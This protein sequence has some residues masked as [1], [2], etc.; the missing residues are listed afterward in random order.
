MKSTFTATFI[1]FTLI[2]LS[3]C[4]Q[5][6]K[7]EKTDQKDSLSLTSTPDDSLLNLIQKQTFTYFW[8]GAEPN[9][10]LA[11]ERIHIDGVY[12]LNDQNVI[13]IGGSGFGLMGMLVAMERQFITKEQGYERLTKAL[14][15]LE[16]IERFH[17]AWAHW[18]DGTTGEAKPFSKND[19]GGDIVETSFMAQALI[20]IREYYKEG[21]DKEKAL[22]AK[23]DELWKGIDFDFYRNGKDVLSWHWS[24]TSEW[25]MNHPIQGY[26]ECLITYILAASSPTHAIPAS[27]YHQGWARNGAIKTDAKKYGIPVVLKHNALENEVGPLFWEH[28]SYL[29]LNP[30]GLKDQYANYA[31]VTKNHVLINIEYA[32]Q[33]PNH[34][35]GY[36]ADKGWGLT[37]S[38]T[39]DG[40]NAHHPDN[41]KSVISPTA[42]LSSMPYTPKESMA[43][44]KYA[45]SLGDKLWG[46]HGFYDAYS[47]TENWFPQQYL[48][49]DQGPI[50]VMIENYRTKLLWDLFM[51]AADV[52][53]GL[54]K[55]GF[56]SPYSK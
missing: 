17:G 53:D 25:E 22:A 26:D 50:V 19:N 6:V 18:Y 31:E 21:T 48:A 8:E 13:T 41:D 56:T 2:T 16:K 49:I 5:V 12:P 52:Q 9:S 15:F 42:A 32:K 33:N 51:N 44:A 24:P 23:A 4:N 1:L 34:Y 35:V 20:C 27:T 11:R 7:Q 30:N 29:G 47:E 3:S 14:D 38:Y 46:K 28:Y 55:L 40:Y 36:G 43:F 45:F 54:K 39:I 37:A 10:G